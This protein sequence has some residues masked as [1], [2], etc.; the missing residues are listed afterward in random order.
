MASSFDASDREP[1]PA[2]EGAPAS[3][4]SRAADDEQQ[5]M[6]QHHR[7]LQE[8]PQPFATIDMD[9]RLDYVNDAFCNLMGY[10]REELLG[11]SVVDL[12]DPHHRDATLDAHREILESGRRTTIVKRYHR[13]D[14]R[15]VPVELLIDARRDDQGRVDGFFAFITEISERIQAQ[16]AL[17]ASERRARTIFEGIHDAVLVHD[18][19]GRILDANRAASEL[20]D[21][22]RGEL[23]GMDL[24]RIDDAEFARGFRE[25][26]ERVQEDGQLTSETTY[27]AKSGRT[28][29]V[30][31]I[32]S[33]I[34][35]DGQP[36]YLAIIRDITDR[37][38]LDRTR[39][40]FAEVQMKSAQALEAKNRELTQSEERY[41]RLTEG[42]LDAIIVTDGG[43]RI[44]LFNP[45]AEAVFGY[46]APQ[47][48]GEPLH[49]LIPSTAR[50]RGEETGP[51]VFDAAEIL[52]KTV[53]L[54]GRRHDGTEFPIE[55][56]FSQVSSGGRL[57]YVASIRDQTERQRMRAMLAHTDKLA[58]IG[59][60]S[61]G[62]AHEIN[63]PLSYVANNLAV[64]RRDVKGLMEMLILAET[65]ATS[66]E[67]SPEAVEQ[68][69]A[70]SEE[71]DWPYIRQ[72]LEPMLD[73]TME[74]VRRVANIVQ[75]MRGLARTS[76]PKWE[77]ASL[78]E[79][80]ES[81]LEMTRGRLKKDKIE[82]GV[83]NLGAECI[84]C[85]P[86]DI[87]QVLLNLLINALQAVEAAGKSEG[88]RIDIETRTTGD[89]V[90]IS[91][92]DN[93]EGIAPDDVGR[94]FDPFFTTKP[95][96]EGT[97]LGLAI[98]HGII[99]GHGGRIEVE[100]EPGRGTCFR[101][102]LPQ[103]EG[104]PAGLRR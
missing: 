100:S 101:I 93:G 54:T 3:T 60:L 14:G 53:E 81:A 75:K 51:A 52:N 17:A 98:S 72:N 30:E 103:S 91:V 86:S 34:E 87:S 36:A 47:V 82:V 50:A 79:L 18:A 25:R 65:T 28:I 5:L 83:Q 32:T 69:A 35:I 16:E 94:L 70:M 43:G 6:R 7:M 92:R 2:V 49:I 20:L 74:G 8:G 85:V 102:L 15:L 99:T 67:R 1:G 44:L 90:E 61:A 63:N 97:G 71:I 80:I 26:L 41:R 31:I 37:I 21:Y 58:S 23:T 22:A 84:D 24:G 12:T 45:S 89:W 4:G 77:R 29:P 96:G 46:E 39:R 59:L 11:R 13:K 95:V 64:L 42:S 9:R 88:G 38:A 55:I 104:A 10:S 66:A 19:A 57:E 27:R 33:T 56:S 76:R 68:L 62:V 78:T 40:R 73:R 48:L